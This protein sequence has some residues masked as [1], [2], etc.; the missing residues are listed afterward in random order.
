M[1]IIITVL[2]IM[3]WAVRLQAEESKKT[4]EKTFPREEIE[5]LVITNNYGKIE[6]SQT[7]G[8]EIEVSALM[9]VVAKS[10]VKADETLELIEVMESR[11]GR[12]LSLETKY[13]KDMAMKQFLSGTS[14][15]VDYK[16]VMPKGMKLRLIAANGNIYLGNFWGELNVDLRN[17]DF[18]GGTIKDGAFY[19]KQD[20]GNFSV[21]EVADLEGDF[22]GCTIQIGAAGNVRLTTGSCDGYIE[23]ADKLN[24]R[25]SGGV[26]KLGDIEEL[27]GSSSFTKYEVQDLGGLMDMDMKMGEMNVR[28][29]QLMFSEI[30]LKG[31][32]TKVG[33]TFM[34]EAGYQLEVKH[35]KSLKLDLPAAVKLE[36]QPTSERNRTVGKAVVGDKKYTGKVMLDLTNGSLFVQ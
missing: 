17:G 13:G 20:K 35:N 6:V 22:K 10:G 8:D 31:S 32:F 27:M 34:K 18:K 14:V 36:E 7:E 25:S 21:E 24:I 19:I 9:R 26:M 3:A 33:L 5:E 15:T 30:R 1:K 28:N 2:C 29:V 4:Y 16:V 23:S 12:Y 11:S